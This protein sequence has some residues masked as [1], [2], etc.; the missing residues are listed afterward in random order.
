MTSV[1]TPPGNFLSIDNV[2]VSSDPVFIARHPVILST[3][4]YL[5]DPIEFNTDQRLI[6]NTVVLQVSGSVAQVQRDVAQ[7]LTVKMNGPLEYLSIS[8]ESPLYDRTVYAKIINSS[9][10]QL[11]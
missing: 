5:N 8:M 11:K 10:S 2:P 7:F 4:A 3:D 6:P 9:F 1:D